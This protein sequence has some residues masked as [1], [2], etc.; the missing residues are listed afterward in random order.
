ME[1]A[2][3]RRWRIRDR[4]RRAGSPSTEASR[5][6]ATRRATRKKYSVRHRLNDRGVGVRL[7]RRER[8]IERCCAR[9]EEMKAART[10]LSNGYGDGAPLFWS[11]V[12][13]H[14]RS[15]ARFTRRPGFGHHLN[16]E[17][18]GPSEVQILRVRS[19]L[20]RRKHVEPQRIGK[21]APAMIGSPNSSHEL[22]QERV[23]GFAMDATIPTPIDLDSKAQHFVR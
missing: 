1:D 19:V 21:G 12:V 22:H 13:P 8:S 4:M 11:V 6:R 14:L 2:R 10:N 3:E 20:R 9:P 18:Y 15:M 5:A 23:R 16:S 7:D 17:L